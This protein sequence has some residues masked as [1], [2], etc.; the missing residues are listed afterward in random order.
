LWQI[1]DEFLIICSYP[2]NRLW[3][4]KGMWDVEALTFSRQSAH[5]WRWGRQPFA[6]A[7]LYPQE[8]PG[9]SFLTEIEIVF[10]SLRAEWLISWLI[11]W[12][13]W[14]GLYVPPK[15]R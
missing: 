7:V 13:W 15:H 4:P 1:L 6:L 10:C 9:Y 3:R 5:R 14:W 11:R 2:C 12:P 8:Y